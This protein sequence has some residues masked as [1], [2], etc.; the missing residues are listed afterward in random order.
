VVFPGAEHLVEKEDEILYLLNT[1][2]ELDA[3]LNTHISERIF[4]VLSARGF[5]IKDLIA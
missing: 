2:K 3:R 4:R 1:Y 5:L